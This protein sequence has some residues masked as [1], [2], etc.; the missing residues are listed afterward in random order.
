MANFLGTYGKAKPPAPKAPVVQP[1]KPAQVNLGRYADGS[2]VNDAG[3]YA[4]PAAGSYG[5]GG[6]GGGSAESP[7]PPPHA[8]RTPAMTRGNAHAA[9]ASL[10]RSASAVA[11]KFRYIRGSP[12][13]WTGWTLHPSGGTDGSGSLVRMQA[14][15]L[16]LYG[17]RTRKRTPLKQG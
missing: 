17:G 9:P 12:G 4:G 8:A 11:E 13:L 5:G 1:K 16:E 2:G 10:T 7:P 15:C 6:G 3:G 14:R